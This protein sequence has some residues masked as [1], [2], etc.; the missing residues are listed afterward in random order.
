MSDPR[1]DLPTDLDREPAPDMIA[2]LGP[3]AY[4]LFALSERGPL[5]EVR[6]LADSRATHLPAQ[7]ERAPEPEPASRSETLLDELG[8][9]DL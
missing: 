6:T 9:L 8:N 7:A 5:A 4:G 3:L 1:N 2:E